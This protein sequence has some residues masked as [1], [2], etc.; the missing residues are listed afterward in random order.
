MGQLGSAWRLPM[1]RYPMLLGEWH[2]A[3][4]GWRHFREQGRQD[5]QPVAPRNA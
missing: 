5:R 4:A 1:Y 3:Q 2:G